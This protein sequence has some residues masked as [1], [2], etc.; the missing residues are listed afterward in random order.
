M[1]LW[2]FLQD[3]YGGFIPPD[4]AIAQLADGGHHIDDARILRGISQ[5]TEHF[6]GG[7]PLNAVRQAELE[8]IASF[9]V[10]L[11]EGWDGVI[12]VLTEKGMARVCF[13]EYLR[14]KWSL[15]ERMIK[16]FEQ[17][18]RQGDDPVSIS[19]ASGRVADE[20]VIASVTALIQLDRAMGAYVGERIEEFSFLVADVY[21]VMRF[22]ADR[23]LGETKSRK[24][25]FNARKSHDSRPQVLAMRDVKEEFMRWQRG[26]VRYMN[27]S[28]F[29]RKMLI[30]HS[31]VLTN[32]TSIKNN[33]TKWR[34]EMAS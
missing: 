34:R 17:R 33:C 20:M 21:D 7:D 6:E 24:A 2:D 8:E 16:L 28:D 25:K 12:D 11:N 30:R 9:V 15:G 4:A 1:A 29:A 22:V 18:G 10:N 13:D 31:G 26:L 23:L 19:L 5:A 14:S 3:A 32:E 27:D